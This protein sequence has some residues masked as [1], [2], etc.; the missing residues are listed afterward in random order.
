M[1]NTKKNYKYIYG[2]VSS[3]RLGSS[4]GVDPISRRE[5][6]CTFDCIYCQLGR[7]RLFKDKREIFIPTGKLIKEIKDLSRIDIDYITFSGRGE[8]TLAKNLGEMIAEIKKIRK[9][10]IAVITNSSLIDRKDVQKDLSLADFV[11]AKLDASCGELFIKVNKPMKTIKFDDVLRGIKEFRSLYEGKL[12][13]QIMFLEENKVYAKEISKIAREIAP[14]EV[15]INTPLRP[16]EVNPLS[17]E[18]IDI[19]K[20]YFEGMNVVSVYD[21]KK[22]DVKPVSKADTLRRRGK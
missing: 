4:L 6:I 2:P 17:K 12:A 19:L 20:G 1:E 18:E 11:M 15:E 14:D 5:K 21:V 3:W 10:K 7:T 8:P 9:E 13:L 22:K 16:C